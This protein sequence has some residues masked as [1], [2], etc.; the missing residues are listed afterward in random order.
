MKRNKKHT[1]KSLEDFLKYSGDQMN[2]SE[3]NQFEKD[4]QKDPFD[5]EA[6]EGLSTLSHEET[7][8]DMEELNKR[9]SDRTEKSASGS[10]RFIFYRIAAAVVAILIVGTLI[11]LLT[12]DLSQIF[13]K[14]AVTEMNRSEKENI[15]KGEEQ[16]ESF[17]FEEPTIENEVKTTMAPDVDDNKTVAGISTGDDQ[18]TSETVEDEDAVEDN[19]IQTAGERIKKTET[20]EAAYQVKMD[21]NMKAEAVT[22]II[23]MDKSLKPATEESGRII[24]RKYIDNYVRGVVLSSEDQLPLPGAT[25]RIRGTTAG[26]YTDQNGNFELPVLPD[27][28]ITL[29][30]DYIGME[31]NEINI[32]NPEDIQITLSPSE[33]ALDEV[34]VVGYGMQKKSNISGAVSA[35]DLDEA[36][37]YQLPSPVIGNRKYKEYVKENLHYPSSDTILSRAVVVL[38]FIVAENGR[39]KNITVLKS[40]GRPFSEEAIRLLVSG[41]DWIPAQLNGETIEEETMIRIIFKPDY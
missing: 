9:I 41:P 22:E 14:T 29:V 21:D 15:M 27:T 23:P 33:A 30:A 24:T 16:T 26:T 1:G 3:R 5:M 31:Q 8:R 34:V 32:D 37:D 35:I 6:A 13:R 11:V 17:I 39:P 10:N 18:S 19:D 12:S 40:P 4:L 36:P 28:S 2:G 38:N 25:V 20:R 7:V